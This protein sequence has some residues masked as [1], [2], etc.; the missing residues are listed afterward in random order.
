[1]FKNLLINLVAVVVLG[2]ALSFTAVAQS[3]V[4]GGISG[5]VT[6]P[7]GA[8]VPNASITVT[9]IGTNKSVTV[10]ATDDGSYRVPNLPPGT[11]RVDV[12]AGNFAASK[13]ENIVVEVGQVTPVD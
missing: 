10:T 12:T 6:D 13:A 4:T 3:T 5:K 8:I 1:M 11:Y 2:L 9:N 7:Q